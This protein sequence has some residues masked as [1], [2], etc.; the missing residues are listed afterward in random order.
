MFLSAI[1]NTMAQSGTHE[2]KNAYC[3]IK[4]ILN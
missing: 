1:K 2:L 4:P 3:L